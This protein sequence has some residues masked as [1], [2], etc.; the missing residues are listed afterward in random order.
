MAI[1]SGANASTGINVESS[2][3]R[4]KIENS[5]DITLN[6]SGIDISVSSNN[7]KVN[8]GGQ[9][10]VTGSGNLTVGNSANAT[11]NSSGIN[12]TGGGA[13]VNVTGSGSVN[14]SSFGTQIS[15]IQEGSIGMQFL[16]YSGITILTLPFEEVQSAIK[17]FIIEHPHDPTRYLVHGCLEGPEGGVYYRGTS[18][19]TNNNSTIVSLPSYVPGWAWEF[20]TYVT[21]IYDG[22]VK[23]YASSEVE[24]N[25]TFKVYG[26]NGKFNWMA[27]GKR[28]LV[29]AEP[30][31]SEINVKGFGPYK[32]IE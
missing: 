32:W 14:I 29:I 15:P 13:N 10:N 1:G 20:T 18:E 5:G 4:I 3:G 21:A 31:K 27:V 11:I 8:T 25:G 17:N 7:I 16:C 28:S 6:S 19:I 22:K 2:A 12:L 26:E 9:V 30:L 24:S 23:V